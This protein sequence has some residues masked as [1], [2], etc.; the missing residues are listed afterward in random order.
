MLLL[1][2]LIF[3]GLFCPGEGIQEPRNSGPLHAA[4]E[5]VPVFHFLQSSSF[6]NNSWA[7]TQ[8]S[9]WLG[10][11]QTHGWDKV[12]DTIRYLRT[13]SRG[14]FSTEELKNIQSLFQLYFHGF[15][16]EVQAYASQFQFEYPFELQIS[17]GC[18]MHVGKPS[19]SFLNGAYQGTDFLSFQGNSWLPSPGAGSQA[20]KVCRVLNKYLDIK[21]IV[22]N[23]LSDTCP[24]FLASLLKAGKAELERQVKPEVWVS[25]GPTPGPGRLTLVCHLAGFH[26]KP[27]W[28]MW[29]RGKQ[30]QHGTRR[31]DVL[32][33]ADETWYLQVTLDVATGEAAG[34]SCQVKH[35]SLGG[36]DI[37]IYWEGSSMFQRVTCLTAIVTAIALTALAFSFQRLRSSW[38]VLAP[39]MQESVTGANTQEPR[40]PGY[41]FCSAWDWWAKNRFL[42]KWKAIL[43]RF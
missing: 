34:L 41:Q 18:S 9:G 7:Y 2:L 8:G 26:P 10:E 11:V 29:M 4:A 38:N 16:R 22:Q 43:N 6:V 19:E 3:K 40:S 23:L 42:K 31:G 33:N 14:N 30:E 35:S 17:A 12:L 37:I 24:R 13:W 5:E 36:H 25:K 21:E 15:I 39:N 1:L 32:P 27:V 20:Q 28:V